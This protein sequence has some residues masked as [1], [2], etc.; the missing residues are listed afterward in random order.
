[1]A[2]PEQFDVFL[3][4]TE[5]RSKMMA[6]IVAMVRDFDLAEDLFQ[7]TVLEIL[8]GAEKFD[9][10]R[11]FLPWASGVARNVVRR[12]WRASERQPTSASQDVLDALSEL[13]VEEQDEDVWQAERAA[14]HQ[15]LAKLPERMRR[16]FVL[17]YGDNHKAGKLAELSAFP[18]GSLRTTLARLRMKLRHCI[19]TEIQES[20]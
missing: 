16:L 19:N 1:M 18:I 3:G 17:R 20:N 6:V 8:Q 5:N 13:A 2:E 14:L 7:Q 11:D 9:A 4:I 15:C 10:T 12:H